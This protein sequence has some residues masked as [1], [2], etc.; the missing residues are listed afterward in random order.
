MSSAAHCGYTVRIKK[1]AQV[2][3]MLATMETELGVPID[4]MRLWKVDQRANGSRRPMDCLRAKH[5]GDVV[6]EDHMSGG[7][8]SRCALYMEVRAGACM[9][10]SVL[11]ACRAP[12]TH[13]HSTH[14]YAHAPIQ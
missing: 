7:C 4:R 1:E 14:A 5:L 10:V 11:T 2:W 9:G 13:A 6:A 8:N 3:Q 12:R